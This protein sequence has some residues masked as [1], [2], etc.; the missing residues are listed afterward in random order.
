MEV[1]KEVII[2]GFLVYL[3]VHLLLDDLVYIYL[4]IQNRNGRNNSRV[5]YNKTTA[6]SGQLV[7]PFSIEDSQ[8]YNSA[9]HH[10][11]LLGKENCEQNGSQERKPAIVLL[12]SKLCDTVLQSVMGYFHTFTTCWKAAL[13]SLTTMIVRYIDFLEFLVKSLTSFPT[14]I[15][16]SITAILALVLMCVMLYIV[17]PEAQK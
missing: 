4:T 15:Y 8:N 12:F 14:V 11:V 5:N 6:H 3:F 1:W 16:C 13:D 10:M 9:E 2:Y 17:L 7:S